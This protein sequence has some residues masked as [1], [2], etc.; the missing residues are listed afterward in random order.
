MHR[1]LCQFLIVLVIA[2]APVLG[3]AQTTLDI[4]I[5]TNSDD[6]EEDSGAD[7]K[8]N[9]SKIELGQMPWAGFRFQNV[10]IPQGATITTAYV[11]FRAESSSTENT[12]L[13]VFGDDTDNSVTFSNSN[14]LSTRTKTSA[15]ASWQNVAN[16]SGGN[17]YQTPE[18]NTIV[19]EIVDRGGWSS[20]NSLAILIRSDDDNGKRL[21]WARDGSSSNAAVLHVE[22]LSS[23][24]YYVR[25]DGSN[26]NSGTGSSASEA[27][28]TVSSAVD[29]VAIDP[30]DRVYVMPGTYNGS[31]TPTIDGSSGSPIQFI[32][33][34][35][36]SIFGTAGQVILDAPEESDALQ[37]NS[38]DYLEFI[39]FTIKGDN[40]EAQSV[41][42]DNSTG[43]KLSKCRIYN[44]GEEGI[45]ISNSTVEIINCQIYDN[46]S[47][48]IDISG[49]S[50]SVTVWNSTIVDNGSDGVRVSSGTTTITNSIL[51]LNSDDG[52]DRD[53][54]TLNH[55]YNII[56]GNSGSAF[57]GTSQST[58]E[59]TSDPLF[60]NAGGFDF[61]LQDGSPAIDAGTNASGTVDD[62]FIGTARPIDSLWDLG[63]FEGAGSSSSG[64]Q[65]YL[66]TLGSATLGGQSFSDED[67][68]DY[69]S[70]S[71]TASI[72]FDG[73]T[74]FSSDE[75]VDAVHVRSDGKILLSTIDSATIGSL[76]FNDEDVVEYDPGTGTATMFFDGSTVFSSDEDL[77]AFFLKSDGKMLI[78]TT[79]S[80]TI[81]SLNFN[82]EDVVEYD[83]GTGTATMYF[84]GSTIF[85]SDEDVNA[86]AL[87]DNGNI[88]V[89]TTSS[90]SIG[91][92][93]FGDDDLIEYNAGTGTATMIFDGGASF[94]NT[95]EDIDAVAF[96]ETTAATLT[97]AIWK[98][99][100][101]SGAT[102]ADSSGEGSDGT[103]TNG[104]ALNTSGPYPGTG[105]IAADFDG[106]NDHVDL[107][108]MN[109][110]FSQG[111]SAAFW[112]N[113]AS[114]PT[115][116][117][118]M[119]GISNG[120]DVDDIW[121]GW[122]PGTGLE[123]Y[124][125]DTVDSTP[126]RWLDDNVEPVVGR[127]QHFAA[128]VD[129]SGNAKIYRDGVEV[130]SG[131]V[132]L[133]GNVDRTEN[134][135]G[136]SVWNEP[137]DGQMFDVHVYNRELSGSEVADLY[138][139]VGHWAF[140]EG[141]GTT[142]ADSSLN[143]NDASFNTGS[144]A[145][146]DGIYGTAL[147]FDGTN[148]AATGANFDPPELGAVSFWFRSDG[149]PAS[150]QRPWGLGADYEIWQDTDGL[151]SFDVSTVGSGGGFITDEA[152]DTAG[153]WYHLV[154]QYD[155]TTDSFEI[156]VNGKLHKSGVST[157]DIQKQT[158]NLLSFGT[159]TGTTQRFDGALDEFRI[160]NRWLSVAEINDLYGRLA[161][162]KLDE[163]SGS[164]AADATQ[165][166]NDGSYT[167]SPTLG[168]N[169]A[170]AAGTATA[171]SLDGST[172]YVDVGKPLI[173]DLG[174]FTML[175]W[176]R[177]DSLAADQSFFGQNNV[178]EF[179]LDY[180]SG[181][182]HL[183][184]ENGGSIDAFNQ[185]AV[186]KWTHVAVTGNG[187]EL[188]LYIN[189]R[190]NTTGG[191]PTAAYGTST[192]SFRLG[193][194]VFNGFGDYFD[195][196]LDDV[197]VFDRALKPEE[198][199]P[200]YKG[201][202]P[203]GVRIIEWLEVR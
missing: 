196:R 74:I 58:G 203:A 21:P 195:G 10:T 81:G 113:P 175:G 187:T 83:P 19:Q 124:F 144:P 189:G 63:C 177:A 75:D 163:T 78:S 12:D 104:V 140:D 32:A 154:G 89:S 65:I 109:F 128:T 110:D 37:I 47:H 159:R 153:R 172:G 180:T 165:H 77:D 26:S 56:Y 20:G 123:L 39:G 64:T 173:N 88:V 40:D 5:S 181:Q 107:P 95:D 197:Q 29:K 157:W 45:D 7:V 168:V 119:L 100:E 28:A 132:S 97:T 120:Q 51:A 164:V 44:A 86:V 67:V 85:S 62:D 182:L 188:T 102:A 87:L 106:T 125:S 135:I 149:P 50:S 169:G 91:G 141:S 130:A 158:A 35:D 155:S 143:A 200:I 183:Y 27:W 176:V 166:G 30:G 184:T 146:V 60:F 137:F 192:D 201:G 23:T 127:W 145:W 96:V 59:L 41:D 33:D 38:D 162:W 179:G 8:L 82:N 160:Y 114:T 152:L 92:L 73:G 68:V 55:T 167:G 94:S 129:S 53:G 71:G 24:T 112:F 156:Y 6:A 72:L 151:I 46:S 161:Y 186:G 134:S 2:V 150:R 126:F 93:S 101:A 190:E 69:D 3:Y 61:R 54:G 178:I 194:G 80:A 202:R 34:T 70:G 17:T 31:V 90:A 122:L 116:Q 52:L 22:Y 148:D 98:L 79:G 174:A 9:N 118:D 48:G 193:E 76:S 198:L 139:L 1:F 25:P 121:I 11:Q 42:I 15:S 99:D 138:G 14:K 18:L 66:S 4:S 131:F 199:F 111:F 170:F 16:W 117:A 142:I 36:G 185:M 57:E 115:L 191:S 147:E 171:V 105:A 136:T 43:V 133:P 84:D 49:S 108:D 13:T 103:Y